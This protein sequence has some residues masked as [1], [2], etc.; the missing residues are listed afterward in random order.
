MNYSKNSGIIKLKRRHNLPE[1]SDEFVVSDVAVSIN[2]V[3]L[4]ESLNLNFL[5][6]KS[7]HSV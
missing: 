6:E 1:S 4:H 7:K 3:V 2:I 5:G